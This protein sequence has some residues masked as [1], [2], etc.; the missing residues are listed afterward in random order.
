VRTKAPPVLLFSWGGLNFKCVLESAGQRFI[1]FMENGIPA[2]AKLSVSFKEYEAIDIEVKQGLFIGPPT[3]RN[4]VEGEN[5]S[6]IAG[7]ALGDPAAWREIA[8][9]NN[10]DNPRKLEPGTTLI[11]PPGKK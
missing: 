3:V 8:E 1:M 7:E 6:G 10:I 4:V 11:V 9:L 5:L 2:R